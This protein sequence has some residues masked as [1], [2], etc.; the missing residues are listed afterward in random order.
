MTQADLAEKLGTRQSAVARLED[1]D[2]GKQSLSVLH[3]IAAI[4]DV[5]AWVE[6]VPFSTLVQRTADLS[7]AALT[8]AP[9]SSEFDEEG[10]PN[11]SVTLAVDGSP[12]CARNFMRATTGGASLFIQSPH[13][14]YVKTFSLDIGK[15]S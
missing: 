15:I 1:P 6:F 4:F 8:P 14:N 11:T 9:Y 7:P 10:Q 5:A 13:V 3:K 12:I 2:Y